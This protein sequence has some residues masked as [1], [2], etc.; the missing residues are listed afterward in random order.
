MLLPM[1]EMLQLRA[2]LVGID[3]EVHR[4]P[5]FDPRLTLNQLHTALQIAFDW[6]YCHMHRF[7]QKDGTRC[8][9]P[10]RF[11]REVNDE[12]KLRLD[13]IFDRKRTR[14]P[15]EYDLGD[16]WMHGVEFEETVQ[17]ETIDDPFETFISEGKGV[18]SGKKRAAKC[19][20][21]ALA[22]P[23]ENCGGI[24]GYF[25]M[26][27]LKKNP[28]AAKLRDDKE[29]LE[30]LGDWEPDAFDLSIVN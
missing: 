3:P 16:S 29:K 22:G 4:T 11:D 13:A 21:G 12:R 15:Y 9:L 7:H 28:S 6:Q 10:S 18:F 23:P 1:S 20:A 19:I 8:G 2:W 25:E 5:V 27:K 24:F 26:L 30:W 14:L 17:S